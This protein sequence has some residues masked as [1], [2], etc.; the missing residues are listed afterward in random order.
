MRLRLIIPLVLAAVSLTTSPSLAQ[1]AEVQPRGLDQIDLNVRRQ[2]ESRG[3]PA[4]RA[5]PPSPTPPVAARPVAAGPVEPPP[6]TMVDTSIGLRDDGTRCTN[7]FSVR[8]SPVSTQGLA[9]EARAIAQ[10]AE[11][12][13]CPRSPLPALPAAPTPATV[14]PDVAAEHVWRELVRLPPPTIAIAPGR[15]VTGLPAYLEIGGPQGE[16]LAPMGAFG[17]AITI[18]T[19]STYDVDWGDGTVV[20]GITS[21]GG[22]HPVGDVHHTYTHVDDANLVTVTQR[23][24]ATWSATGPAGSEGGTIAGVLSTSSSLPLPVGQIQAVRER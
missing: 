22:P 23:W 12:G 16:R 1:E 24:T 21:Q 20:T 17:Y 2:T 7:V 14:R 10:I 4:P 15:A 13:V 6:L 8:G 19:A 9:N 18:T 5:T 3:A 11:Y